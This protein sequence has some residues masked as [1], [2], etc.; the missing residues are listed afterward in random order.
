MLTCAVLM[1][2]D[3]TKVNLKDSM[4]EV[5]KD[6]LAK[7]MAHGKTVYVTTLSPPH[8]HTCWRVGAPPSVQQSTRC[9]SY[10]DVC[11]TFR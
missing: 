11:C 7:L 5:W 4:P 2:H 10:A 3:I 1:T 6:M 8:I 9:F